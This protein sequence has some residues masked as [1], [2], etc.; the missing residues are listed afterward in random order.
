MHTRACVLAGARTCVRACVR[1]C[2]CGCHVC[3]RRMHGVACVAPAAWLMVFCMEQAGT[4][5]GFL[6]SEP[7]SRSTIGGKGCWVLTR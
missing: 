3:M 7:A 5:K 1:A 2:T 4:C 6:G